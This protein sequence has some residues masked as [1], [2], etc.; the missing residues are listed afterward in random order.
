L[1]TIEVRNTAPHFSCGT[2]RQRQINLP[3]VGGKFPP[4][5]GSYRKFIGIMV[6]ERRQVILNLRLPNL[7]PVFASFFFLSEVTPGN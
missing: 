7:T 5:H 6:P 2:E 3:I 4:G 1:R